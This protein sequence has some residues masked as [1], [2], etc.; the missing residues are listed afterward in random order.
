MQGGGL[1]ARG[2]SLLPPRCC[3]EEWLALLRAIFGPQYTD[4]LPALLGKRLHFVA[5]EAPGRSRAAHLAA[6]AAWLAA[7][8]PG[9]APRKAA[10]GY[11]SASL[12]GVNTAAGADAD[13]Y[14]RAPLL[15]EGEA[16]LCGLLEA[17][18][19]AQRLVFL[20]LR[21][22]DDGQ[23]TA[24]AGELLQLPALRELVLD[25]YGICITG[26]LAQLSCLTRLAVRAALL[27]A[28]LPAGL[29]QLEVLAGPCFGAGLGGDPLRIPGGMPRLER[30]V[31]QNSVFHEAAD[32][33]DALDVTALSELEMLTCLD[34]DGGGGPL[35]C[36]D[37][38]SSVP[39]AH[40]L[41]ALPALRRLKRLHLGSVAAEGACSLRLTDMPGLEAS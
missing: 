36:F 29:R 24:L 26:S 27:E 4:R 18:Q 5:A 8:G 37:L 38:K 16:A 39:G 10:L 11:L 28:A 17:V 20:K 35:N 40:P 2:L 25:T 1:C 21:S 30:L 12:P 33:H 7:P 32:E 14:E 19:G 13:P 6:L 22:V 41:S 23:G 34:L 9:G 31:I 3:S 15:P